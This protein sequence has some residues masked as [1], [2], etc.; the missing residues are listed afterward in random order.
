MGLLA[1]LRKLKSAPDRELRILLLG[2]DNAGK[3]TLLK[4]LASEDISHI[5]PT[6]GFNIKSV[7]SSGF[8]LNVWDIGGQRKIRPYWK[9]YFENTD[10]LIYVIDSAD[11]KRFE[12][13]GT[14]L[15]ELLD[16]EKLSGVPLLVFANKQ[17][18]FSA[19][20]AST[21]AEGL[22]LHIIRDR[23][24]QIQACSATNGEGVQDGMKWVLKNVKRCK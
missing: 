24:W 19:A 6:Q 9:N 20:P 14:E 22:N 16:E 8:K 2:L 4:S 18:L 12:E 17:D 7:Q 23:I 1:I 5:T 10:I 21:I 15:G 11:R 3:T 13:T